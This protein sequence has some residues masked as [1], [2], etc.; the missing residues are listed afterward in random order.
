MTT[1]PFNGTIEFA[2]SIRAFDESTV[3]KARVAF[4]YTPHWPYFHVQSRTEKTENQRLEAGLTLLAIPRAGRRRTGPP[5]AG[6]PH[7]VPVGQLL[8][9]GVLRPKVLEQLR[10]RIDVQAQQ[11]D[12]RN[13]ISA[14]FSAPPTAE[15][16]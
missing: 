5:T 3:R 7:W 15:Y 13:R 12:R 16:L 8:T 9:V 6:E 11:A 10:A 4:A 1:P 2:L 14:G